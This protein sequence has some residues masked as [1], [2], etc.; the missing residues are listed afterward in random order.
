MMSTEQFDARLTQ[1]EEQTRAR[2]EPVQGFR[3]QKLAALFL[4]SGW[5][6]DEV[7][8]HLG[9]WWGKEV[10]Q[11]WVGQQLRFARFLSFFTTTGS[12]GGLRLPP[13]LSERAFRSFWDATEAGDNFS[14]HRAHTEAA[15]QDEHRRFGLVLEELK[16]A[17]LSRARKPIRKAILRRVVGKKPLSAEEIAR[18]ISDDLGSAVLPRDVAQT[19]STMRPTPESPYRVEKSLDSEGTKYRVVRTAGKVLSKKDLA[20]LAP[21]LLPLVREIIRESKKDKV[22]MSAAHLCS[23]ASRVEQVLQSVV[24]EKVAQ[25]PEA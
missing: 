3:D 19:L 10:T 16:A 1:I 7:A 25:E 13:N 5:S 12:E 15:V 24:G 21:E 8:A 14:G 9:K 4:D 18:V 6:Q 22:E 11:Q 23:L 20:R 17:G 2:Q